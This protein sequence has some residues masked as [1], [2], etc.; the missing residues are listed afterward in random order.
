MK[1][2]L[3]IELSQQEV[4]NAVKDQPLTSMKL[5]A[6]EDTGFWQISGQLSDNALTLAVTEAAKKG[7]KDHALIDGSTVVVA[8]DGS[9]RVTFKWGDEA[10]KPTRVEK[11]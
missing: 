5:S 9:A 3:Q 1:K 2:T 7:V 11:A 8:I 6:V 4:L 10:V